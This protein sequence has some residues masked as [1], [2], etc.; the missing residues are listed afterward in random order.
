M[1]ER[2]KYTSKGVRER[3]RV[4]TCERRKFNIF[5]FLVGLNNGVILKM[6][7]TDDNVPHSLA[8]AIATCTILVSIGPWISQ[9][10]FFYSITVLILIIV[11]METINHF[12]MMSTFLK[13]LYSQNQ[14]KSGKFVRR[15]AIR[16]AERSPEPKKKH[17]EN[18]RKTV[19]NYIFRNKNEK[20][21]INEN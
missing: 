21:I 14:N 13:I 9:Y 18:R 6:P 12:G 3:E 7:D 11:A 16:R 4:T 20:L 17:F 10:Y 15:K 2:V 19:R 8:S 5:I 1:G